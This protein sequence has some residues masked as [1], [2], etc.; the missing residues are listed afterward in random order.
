MDMGLPA[1]VEANTA[2]IGHLSDEVILIVSTL[3]RL[4][5]QPDLSSTSHLE[6]SANDGGRTAI[7]CDAVRKAIQVRR[8]RYKFFDKELFADPAWDM[9]LELYQAEIAQHRVTVS[10]LCTASGVPITT[11]LRWIKAMTE[12]D[13]FRR[14][15]DPH[16]ARRF[17][18]EL[19]P[20]AAAG[21]GSYF[22][23]IG[24]LPS[25]SD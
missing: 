24:G 9:L 3:A 8:L 14:H 20:M 5:M 11:A 10:S 7:P 22:E 25:A 16:D 18:V 1:R 19:S 21:M 17:F 15:A 12:A 6:R 4:A 2:K 13:L 23:K